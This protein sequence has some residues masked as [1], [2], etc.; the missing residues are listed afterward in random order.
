MRLLALDD[1]RSEALA[2]YEICQTVHSID[3]V[4]NL[5]D[6]VLHLKLLIT[7]RMRLNLSSEWILDIDGLDFPPTKTQFTQ[8]MENDLAQYSAIQLFS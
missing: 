3:T 8:E 1:K 6:N 4:T 2:Q 7:S 5:L